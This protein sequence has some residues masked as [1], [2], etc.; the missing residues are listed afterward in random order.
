MTDLETTLSTPDK[1]SEKSETR[2]ALCH[3]QSA[4]LSFADFEPTKKDHR[5]AG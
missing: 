2:W 1:S 5:H 4:W 3:V